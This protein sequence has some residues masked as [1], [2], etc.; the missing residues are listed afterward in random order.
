MTD[1]SVVKNNKKKITYTASIQGIER[2]DNALKRLGFESKSANLSRANLSD[3]NLS[4]A[5]LIDANVKNARFGNNQGISEPIK[6]DL[7]QK[8]AI[9]EDSQER[10]LGHSS[11][12]LTIVVVVR[13]LLPH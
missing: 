13:S 6:R 10:S 11:S 4:D 12:S 7:I 9:F 8:G 2:A 1:S 3:A 5:N